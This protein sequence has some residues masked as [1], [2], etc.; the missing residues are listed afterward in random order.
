MNKFIRICLSFIILFTLTLFPTMSVYS[1]SDY[2]PTVIDI[3]IS[4]ALKSDGTVWSWG[5]NWF[6]H[7]GDGTKE[8]IRLLPVQIKGLSDVESVYYTA[9]IK[10]DGTVWTWGT[11]KYGQ[12]G[13]GTRTDRITPVQVKG[14]NNVKKLDKNDFFTLALL[15]DGTVWGWGYNADWQLG[16]GNSKEIK[17]KS[18][19]I[20]DETEIQLSVTTPVRVKGLSDVID[21]TSSQHTSVVLKN[22]GTVWMWGR[23]YTTDLGVMAYVKTPI[24]L[25]MSN[26]IDVEDGYA[27]KKDGTVWKYYF[28]NQGEFLE[29]QLPGFKDI[30]QI[31]GS[32]WHDGAVIGLKADGTV[33]AYGLNILGYSE[34]VTN[35][36]TERAMQVKPIT[37]ATKVV[38]GTFVL[39]EDGTVW[40]FGMNSSGDLGLGYRT[41]R[42]P[43]W[44][45]TP[46]KIEAL[47]PS[48]E[49]TSKQEITEKQHIKVRIDGELQ[50]YD[51]PPILINGSTM[52]PMRGIFEAF[53]AQIQW[54]SETQTVIATK[55]ETTI[56]LPIGEDFA[57]INGDT[58]QL[59]QKAVVKNNRT[60]VPI[61]FVSE[62]LGADVKWNSATTS[63][64]ITSH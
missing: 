50:Q 32:R 31:D 34:L 54:D 52:V 45:A 19:Y 7:V 2:H 58:V 56:I 57:N 24:Q 5:D 13:D 41:V 12:L 17:T 48:E 35:Y 33:W 1:D 15:E 51:Q 28:D 26:V 47:S 60:L 14:I 49:N 8:N 40:S 21:I 44:V 16:N 62:A 37:N 6:G 43:H 39:E 63:V 22:D 4:I 30:I 18:F 25:P 9:V 36:S 42:S 20:D 46:Q 61:R 55:G 59:T 29:R 38:L 64:D 3:G 10:K 53:G 11:N 27:I 23:L